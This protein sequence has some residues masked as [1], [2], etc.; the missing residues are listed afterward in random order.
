MTSI[1]RRASASLVNVVV[2]LLAAPLASA[3]DTTAGAAKAEEWP[4]YGRAYDQNHY[5]PLSDI[6]DSNI[7][8]L[9]L[10]WWFDISG[11]GL[12]TSVP[13]EVDGTLYFVTG[14]SIVRAVDATNGHL[15]WTYDPQASSAQRVTLRYA[16]G[17]RGIAFKNHKIFV[18]TQ[19][20]RL[21][22]IDAA[23][24]HPVWIVR[25]I[26]GNDSRFITSAPLAF[27]NTVVVG[28][29]MSEIGHRRGY[30]TAYDS[31]TGK[32]RW[33]FF[34]VPGDPRQGFENDAMAM[35]AKTWSGQWWREG[36]GGFVWNALTYDPQTNRIYFGTSNGSPWNQKF[37]SPGGGDNL[38]LCSI[39][40]LD[41]TTGTYIWHYQTNPGDTW[42][43]DATADLELTDLEIAGK[44]HRVLMQA[45]KNGFF[46]VIDRD[47]GQLLSA[48]KFSAVTWADRIDPATGRPVEAANARYQSGKM[49]LRPGPYGAHGPQPMA[50]NTNTRLVYIPVLDAAFTYDDIGFDPAS[51]R[52]YSFVFQSGLNSGDSDAD[53]APDKDSSWLLAWDPV[54]HQG[55]WRVEVPG[56]GGAGIATTAGN[57]VF[58]GRCDG[59][60]VAYSATDGRTLWSF[61]TQIGI[62]GAPITYKVDHRQYVSVMAGVGG[63]TGCGPVGSPWDKTTQPRR[64]LTFALGAQERLPAA[65]APPAVTPVRDPDFKPNEKTEREGQRWFFTLCGG[66]HGFSATGA[67]GAP[68]LRASAAI[69]S[70]KAFSDIVQHRALLRQGMPSFDELGDGEVES[71]RQFVRSQAQSATRGSIQP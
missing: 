50:F 61:D 8:K 47:N 66:C 68:D 25:T 31:E 29:S 20:G 32:Q 69:T 10:A 62:V 56:L 19:D 58:Q 14:Y 2:L 17:V 35:A 16:Y 21:I 15:L 18:G 37:R 60:F 30:V 45:S 28:N 12:S 48:T 9:G 59:R 1:T 44:V 55:T 27:N 42:D 38:F 70:Q 39:I 52:S 65:P 40:A 6:N 67:G 53:T 64:V 54:K 4:S 5:S 49:R 3:A 7:T 33:R 51:L 71:I 11:R 13:L 63:Y 22:A 41:A 34:T 57:L 26:E 46:Y 23:T 36:G 24:G 43:Y